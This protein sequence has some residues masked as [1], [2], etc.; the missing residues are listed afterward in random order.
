TASVLLA[1]FNGDGRPDLVTAN[2]FNNSLSVLMNVTTD[3]R[4]QLVDSSGAVLQSGVPATNSTSV[5]NFVAPADG[6]YYARV[7]DTR[8]ADYNLVVTRDA[9]FDTESTHSSAMAQNITSRQGVLGYMSSATGGGP[10]TLSAIDVGWWDST[11]AHDSTDKTYTVGQV[12]ALEHR[13]FFV[14][15]LTATTQIITGAQLTSSNP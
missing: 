15:D 13:V 6:T 11:G 4:V 2:P 10:F 9:A 14:F 7:T 5:L 8:S 3:L 12:S 1:D